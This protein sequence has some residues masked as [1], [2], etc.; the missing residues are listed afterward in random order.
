MKLMFKKIYDNTPGILATIL[1]ALAFL[2]SQVITG[3]IGGELTILYGDLNVQYIPFIK[4]FLRVLKGQESFWYSFSIYLGSGTA[5]TYVYYTLCPLNLLYLIDAVPVDV[6]TLIVITIKLSLS[7]ASFS[8]FAR[9]SLKLSNFTSLLFSPAYALSSF[10]AAFFINMIW[11]D[12]L[13]MLPLLAYFTIKEARGDAEKKDRLLFTLSFAYLFITNF[14]IAFM[15]GIFIAM[16]FLVT[17]LDVALVE[18][19]TKNFIKKGISFTLTVILAAGLCACL[20]L[21]AALFLYRNTAADNFEFQELTVTLPDILKRFFIG[22]IK[23]MDNTRPFLY[24]SIPALLLFPFFFTIKEIPLR[25][26]LLAGGITLFYILSMLILPLYEFMHAFDF[27]NF[28]AFRFSFCLIFFLLILAAI[29]FEKYK[30]NGI[31]IWCFILSVF[32]SVMIRLE[33]HYIQAY[34]QFFSPAVYLINIIFIILW[35][36]FIFNKI[37]KKSRFIKPAMI[38]L[39]ILELTA[40]L[41][42]GLTNRGFNVRKAVVSFKYTSEKKAS[43]ELEDARSSHEEKAFS[44][45]SVN[46]EFIH[47]AP[48]FSGYAGFNSFSSSDDY[49]LRTL[50]HHLGI[51]APNRVI[52]E[53]GYTPV[54]YA[55]FDTGY[56]LDLPPMTLENTNDPQKAASRISVNAAEYAVPLI[57]LASTDSLNYS[58]GNDPFVNQ[59]NLISSLTGEAYSFFSPVPKEDILIVSSNTISDLRIS[60]FNI[61]Y[62]KNKAVSDT[63]FNYMIDDKS[64]NDIY[65]CFTQDGSS[66]DKNSPTLTGDLYGMNQ[67]LK[68][69]QGT[70]IKTAKKDNTNYTTAGIKWDPDINVGTCKEIYI[71]AYTGEKNLKEASKQLEANGLNIS[72]F[73]SDHIKGKLNVNSNA[74]VLMTTIPYDTDWHIYVDGNEAETSALLEEAFLGLDHLEPGDHEI[75]LKYIP[76][77]F[78]EGLIVSIAALLLIISRY[79]IPISFKNN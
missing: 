42:I 74:P 30:K 39:I 59:D 20:L 15:A 36:L 44:R 19:N 27:P 48:S 21:P 55:L 34:E 62:K 72:E 10:S 33:P 79:F 26:R 4:M 14:Y 77:G 13:Y 29:S 49:E 37:E 69:S 17:S 7:A 63:A 75:E 45:I 58:S 56:Y 38:I 9:K 43:S 12:A 1:T 28:Y 78:K 65:M 32:Y 35:G 40:N 71:Y 41:S 66:L 24:C 73:S 57:F 11:L 31:F 68:F 6:M 53:Q 52:Y 60:N 50:L 51:T 25:T 46:H 76:S 16:L 61:F 70:I 8:F 22:E 67:A 54:T 47:N 2:A 5:L 64:S 23:D 3:V 18:K